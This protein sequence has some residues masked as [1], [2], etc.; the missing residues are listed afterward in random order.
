MTISLTFFTMLDDVIST[1]QILACF[2]GGIATTLIFLWLPMLPAHIAVK[3][4]LGS[5]I[6]I[7]RVQR[8]AG[9]NASTL[10]KRQSSC[11]NL[12]MILGLFRYFR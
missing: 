10:A 8:I 11:T 6:E 1:W 4:R 9:R 12:R 3:G 7:A 2:V 5:I